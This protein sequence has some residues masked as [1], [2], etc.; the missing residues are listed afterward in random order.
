MPGLVEVE[1]RSFTYDKPEGEITEI[2][3]RVDSVT[4]EQVLQFYE[5]SLP[6][7][8]WSRVTEEGHF[9]RKGEYL[10][11]TFEADG[12]QTYVRIMIRPS[13]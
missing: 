5:I 13:R 7:F 1:D 8:G 4:E 12:D 2:V 3:A 9:F 10:D 6:Q 11:I